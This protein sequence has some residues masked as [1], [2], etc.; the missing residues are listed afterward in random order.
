M[1][2]R[3]SLRSYQVVSHSGIG[4][5]TRVAEHIEYLAI[6][7]SLYSAVRFAYFGLTNVSQRVCDLYSA[8]EPPKRGII[9]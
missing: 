2:N 3:I 7:S 1:K 5:R 4:D 6:D 8:V 9:G